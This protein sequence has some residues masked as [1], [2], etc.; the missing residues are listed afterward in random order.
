[1]PIIATDVTALLMVYDMRR[2]VAFYRDVLGFEVL[3]N[4]EPD[5]HLYW[6]MLRL[7]GARLMLNAEF[8]D[9]KRPPALMPRRPG[10]CGVILYFSCDDV[11]QAYEHLRSKGCDAK[12]PKTT[13]Y[14][15]TQLHVTDPDGFQL[16]F[17]QPSSRA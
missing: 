8:E 2:S 6:V 7:G 13:Y 3:Q 9:D 14:G 16:C 11:Q 17:Q 10:D 1:V 12:Q 4:H 15:M 5:G